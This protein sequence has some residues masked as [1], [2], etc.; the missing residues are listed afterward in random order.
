M[1]LGH[2]VDR[3]KGKP[4]LPG[5]ISHTST[6]CMNYVKIF[7]NVLDL[8]TI[9]LAFFQ[10]SFSGG[11][12]YCYADFSCYANF[13]IVFRPNFRRPLPSLDIFFSF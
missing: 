11:K 8:S 12:I 5:P 13:S 10:E 4:G 1:S 7:S 2:L 6:H 3:R 9:N